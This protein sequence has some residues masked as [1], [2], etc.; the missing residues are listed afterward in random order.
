VRLS[1]LLLY[2][3]HLPARQNIEAGMGREQRLWFIIKRMKVYSLVFCFVM[4]LTSF[5]QKSSAQN[6]AKHTTKQRVQEVLLAVDIPVD[7]RLEVEGILTS[8]FDSLNRIFA[9]RKTE[10]ETAVSISVL[11]MA[12]ILLRLS[13]WEVSSFPIFGK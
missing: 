3:P 7:K 13:K 9:I 5:V 12:K 8:H 6:V 11:R 2:L 1:A 4:L 10:M